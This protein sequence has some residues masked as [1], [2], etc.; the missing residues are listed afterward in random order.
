MEAVRKKKNPTQPHE[1]MC[2]A[3]KQHNGKRYRTSMSKQQNNSSFCFQGLTLNF[4]NS[5]IPFPK[6]I[7]IFSVKC[8]LSF[9]I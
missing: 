6:R 7:K 1:L 9:S 5:K 4:I 8:T 3:S 2:W